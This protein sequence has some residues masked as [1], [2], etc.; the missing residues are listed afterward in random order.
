MD[1]VSGKT[2]FKIKP[3]IS[4]KWKTEEAYGVVLN[5]VLK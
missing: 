1:I 2:L 4:Y 3:R 5:A